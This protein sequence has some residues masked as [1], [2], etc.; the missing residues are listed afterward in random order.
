MKLKNEQTTWIVLSSKR[1]HKKL[2]EGLQHQQ[3]LGKGKSQTQWDVT[4]CALGL[5][6]S[7]KKVVSV[8]NDIEEMESLNTGN[9]NMKWI[10]AI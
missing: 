9:K 4:L 6:L 1:V 5:P 7:K 10:Q 8:D 2:W 3:F